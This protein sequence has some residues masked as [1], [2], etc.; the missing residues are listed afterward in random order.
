[1]CTISNT[2]EL[3]NVQ[4]D[5]T[6]YDV[7][8]YNKS[9]MWFFSMDVNNDLYNSGAIYRDPYNNEGVWQ[10][11]GTNSGYAAQ[12]KTDYRVGKTYSVYP[13]GTNN[14]KFCSCFKIPCSD[15]SNR[16]ENTITVR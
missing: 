1:M 12:C 4:Y 15:N 13:T 16:L 11:G 9:L 2:V 5:Q 3:K 7:P 8:C 10:N 14:V 6:I